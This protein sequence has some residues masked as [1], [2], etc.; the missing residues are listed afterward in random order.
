MPVLIGLVCD[1]LHFFFHTYAATADFSIF[2]F[3]IFL[4]AIS[5]QELTN[6]ENT[7]ITKNKDHII[8]FEIPPADHLTRKFKIGRASCRERV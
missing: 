1:P 4:K 3:L 8:N 6:W 5:K 2:S 7:L